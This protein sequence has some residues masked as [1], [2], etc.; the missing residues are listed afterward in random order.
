MTQLQGDQSKITACAME[1]NLGMYE[2]LEWRLKYERGKRTID[3]EQYESILSSRLSDETFR[4]IMN[5][6]QAT[7]NGTTM[8]QIQM[9]LVSN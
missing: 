6:I 7:K 3:L 8:D 9:A 1:R 4:G 2:N 5:F